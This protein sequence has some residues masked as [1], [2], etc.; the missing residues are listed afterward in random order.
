MTD[1]KSEKRA[2]QIVLSPLSGRKLEIARDIPIADLK[3]E[4]GV[5]TLL[6]KLKDYFDKDTVDSAYEAFVHFIEL[7]RNPGQSVS[8]FILSFESAY[9]KLE[10]QQMKRPDA[11]RLLSCYTE[12]ISKRMNVR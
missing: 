10:K 12:R 1:L 11:F 6:T 8:D 3:S 4:N 7:R 2:P 5:T 9:Q